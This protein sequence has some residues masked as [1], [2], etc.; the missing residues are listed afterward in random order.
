MGIRGMEPEEGISFDGIT[1]LIRRHRV[2][3][4][5]GAVVTAG[6]IVSMGLLKDRTYSSQATFVL[7]ASKGSGGVSGIAAQFGVA[8]PIG[9]ASQSP[10]FYADLLHSH[11]VLEPVAMSTYTVRQGANIVKGDLASFLHITDSDSA[12]KRDKL[13]KA[14]NRR[15]F[16]SVDAKTG[17]VTMTVSAPNPS[18]AQQVAAR[19]LDRLNV[20]NLEG[21]QSRASAERRFTEARLVEVSEQLH[22]A[23]NQLEQF[24]ETN[25]VIMSPQLRLEQDRLSRAVTMRQQV[26]TSLAQS[27]EQSKIDE[28]RDL[29]VIT[30]ISEPEVP[31]L[32][33][34]RGLLKKGLMALVVGG[35]AGLA[36]GMWQDRRRR[37][38]ALA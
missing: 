12:L 6:V 27:Y 9:D 28:V 25:R 4:A 17:V 33:D 15:V 2:L 14:L 38:L 5:I 7:Q 36:L 29:P 3:V 10:Q 19:L 34:P 11:Q 22:V 26:Y 16:G 1:R 31:V 13:I 35:A 30:V 18:L 24:L 23:E 8:V 20:F 32:P 37:A 21:R